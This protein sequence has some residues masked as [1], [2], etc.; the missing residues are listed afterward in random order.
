MPVNFR[1]LGVITEIKLTAEAAFTTIFGVASLIFAD[2]TITNA[3]KGDIPSAVWEAAGTILGVGLAVITG[4]AA[5]KTANSAP[6]N[7]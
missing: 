3:G 6:Q 1:E 4:R 2:L 5:L 7:K